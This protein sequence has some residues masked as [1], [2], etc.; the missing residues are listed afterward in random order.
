MKIQMP[1]AAKYIIETLTQNG[2]EAY[3]V[4]G[5]V[6]DSILNKQPQDWDITT[7]ATPE[8]TKSLFR[9]TIDTG[10]E[11]GT[12][13]VM[14]DKTGYEVTTYR[15]DGKYQDHRRPTEVTFTASLAEDLKRRDFTINAMAYNDQD[16]VI[17]E[18]GGLADLERGIIRCV[19]VPQERFDEDALR[20]L[21]AVR[22]AAQLDFA[23]EED[24]GQAIRE[25][26]QFLKDISAERIQTELTK[27]ITSDHPERILDAWELGIT[28]IVL[29]E[30][31]V[32]MKT[33]QHTMYHKYDVGRHTV[34]VMQNIEADPVLRWAALLHDSAKPMCRTTD[35][36]GTDHF[37]GHPKVG[38]EIARQVLRR[39]K[40]DNDTIHRV[41]RLVAWHDYGIDGRVTKKSLRHALNQM[42]PNLFEDYAKL[43]RADMLGQSDYEAE[44]KQADYEKL[45]EL[46][47]EIV[48]DGECLAIKDLR[49]DGK[50]LIRMGVQP[51]PAMGQILNDLLQQ[52]LEDP[53][54]N[55][56]EKL[57]NIV[58]QKYLK[59]K[60]L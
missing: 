3:I 60:V 9:R 26:A 35:E 52:V 31:D 8:Q 59:D 45:L 5:C 37:Y 20:I 27:L 7:S 1:E 54:L 50:A 42:G 44:K 47:R 25:Q 15:V 48:K 41:E 57:E 38:S 49:I 58:R 43:R 28:A 53:Q 4:G 21:R 46:Y 13:T 12:V 34:A 39:M 55:T 36:N 32:M 22:F 17:D 11:H 23:I 19:G 33:P 40:L 10:I 29:P 30:F 6:R 2:Y 56:V 16:G 24:T 14:M 18:F 51:G